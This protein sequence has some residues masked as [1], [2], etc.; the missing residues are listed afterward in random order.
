MFRL[1]AIYT[2]HTSTSGH[3]KYKGYPMTLSDLAVDPGLIS[4]VKV[5]KTLTPVSD[6]EGTICGWF[7]DSWT[8]RILELLYL[9]VL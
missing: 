6:P 9:H 4:V 8:A 1:V 5:H 7:L 3:L 2:E